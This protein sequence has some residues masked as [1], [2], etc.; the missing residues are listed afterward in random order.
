MTIRSTQNQGIKGPTSHATCRPRSKEPDPQRCYFCARVPHQRKQSLF[1]QIWLLY[2]Y[3][4]RTNVAN[5]DA[6]AIAV[7]RS[8]EAALVGPRAELIQSRVNG[9]ATGE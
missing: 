1:S 2:S 9:R 8:L 7:Y 5:A 6:I 4:E 3:L